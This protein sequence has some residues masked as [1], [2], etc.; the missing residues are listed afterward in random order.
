MLALSELTA[1]LLARRHIEPDTVVD[2]GL[3]VVDAAARAGRPD[4]QSGGGPALPRAPARRS[5][6]RRF[7]PARPGRAPALER[8]RAGRE[9]VRVRGLAVRGE[10]RTRLSRRGLAGA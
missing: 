3:T 1:Y 6:V 9:P 4:A 7:L 10:L 5:A 8:A 2:G